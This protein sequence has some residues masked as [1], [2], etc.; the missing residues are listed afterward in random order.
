MANG[1]GWRRDAGRRGD[2]LLR[3]ALAVAVI[4]AV[5]DSFVRLC[6]KKQCGKREPPLLLRSSGTRR[7][8]TRVPFRLEGEEVF[9]RGPL[10]TRLQ[11][12]AADEAAAHEVDPAASLFTFSTCRTTSAAK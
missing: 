11:V 5:E 2:S 9:P 1:V 8:C 3:M 10:A 12:H 6:F 4:H 7:Q